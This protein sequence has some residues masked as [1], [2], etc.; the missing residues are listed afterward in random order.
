MSEERYCAVCGK[1]LKARSKKYCSAACRAQAGEERK[2]NRLKN[3]IRVCK[4]CGEQFT[5]GKNCSKYCSE[6]CRKAYYAKSTRQKLPE[7]ECP[8]CGKMFRP[9]T[10]NRVYCSKQC[11]Q[12]SW[13]FVGMY[14]EKKPADKAKKRQ[15]SLRR[16]M[17]RVIIYNEQHGTNYSYGQAVAKGIV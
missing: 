1:K 6:E 8:V 15:T 12:R 13:T 9:R 11:R 14:E 4:F 10:Y 3:E 16:T 7:R 5:P 17:A 2:A